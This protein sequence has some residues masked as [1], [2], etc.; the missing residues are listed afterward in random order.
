MTDLW[1]TRFERLKSFGFAALLGMLI[2]VG[3]FLGNAGV[4]QTVFIVTGLLAIVP[5]FFYLFA[6]T[7]WHWKARY[8][9]NHS[10]LWGALLLIETSGW[11]KLVYLF[12]HII[13]DARHSGLYAIQEPTTFPPQRTV[14]DDLG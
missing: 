2:L 12:R 7:I 14:V 6:V 10:D 9:G 13:P 8:R 11:F 5:G 4:I 3:A 1:M